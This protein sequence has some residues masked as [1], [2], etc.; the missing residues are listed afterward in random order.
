ML[1]LQI[2][3]VLFFDLQLSVN[4]IKKMC[5]KTIAVIFISLSWFVHNFYIAKLPIPSDRNEVN[6]WH[7]K[8]KCIALSVTF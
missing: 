2:K 6:V 8:L 4:N 1:Q 7:V 5:V 3:K